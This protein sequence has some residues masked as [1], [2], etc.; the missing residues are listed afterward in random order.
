MRRYLFIISMLF[1]FGLQVGKSQGALD[2]LLNVD[3]KQQPLEKALYLLIDKADA[4]LSFSNDIIPDKEITLKAYNQPLSNILDL[5]LRDTDIQYRVV[6]S[7][8]VLYSDQ[9]TTGQKVTISG[10]V[11]DAYSGEALIGVSIYDTYS[12]KGTTT[13]EYGFYSLTLP[14]DEVAIKYSYVGYVLQPYRANLESNTQVDITL[15]P[16]TTHLAMVTIASDSLWSN[17]P[18]G[19]SVHTFDEEALWNLPGFGGEKD[20][21]RAIHLLPGIQT[22]TDGIGGFSVRGGNPDENLILIDDVPVYYFTHGAGLYSIV[23]SDAINKAT[24][25]KNDFPARYNGRLSSILDIRTKEGNKKEFNA[26]AGINLLGVKGYL[27]G[28][29]IPNRSSFFLSARK[30]L[31]NWY[32][33]PITREEKER[34]GEIGQTTYDFYDLNLK[35]NH[36]L[37]NKNHLFLSVYRGNDQF[38]DEGHLH[39]SYYYDNIGGQADYSYSNG[40]NWKNTTTSLRWNSVVSDQMFANLTLIYSRL[41]VDN[42][43]LEIDSSL[44]WISDQVASSKELNISRF[45][46]GIEDI[47]AKLDFD[48]MPSPQHYVRFGFNYTRHFF[49]PGAL[50]FSVRTDYNADLSGFDT[51]NFNNDRA[52]TNEYGAYIENN[53]MINDQLSLDAGLAHVNWE[54][55]DKIYRSWQPRLS[56]YWQ[57]DPVLGVK[58]SYSRMEQFI[59]RLSRSSLGLP[60]DL[61]VP[62][63]VE[64]APKTA[65]VFSLEFDYVRNQTRFSFGGFYKKFDGL[66]EY[67]EGANFLNN[68][69]DNITS[70]Q[71]DSYGLE[72]LLE[73]NMPTTN[74]WLA[75][76]LSY[77][78]RQFENINFGRTY[79][80][81]L[82]RRHSVNLNARHQFNK[83][84]GASLSWVYTTGFAFNIP[85]EEYIVVVP[86]GDNDPGTTSGVPGLDFGAKNELRMPAYHRLDVNLNALFETGPVQHAISIGAYNLYNRKNPLYYRLKR[87]YNIENNSIQKNSRYVQAWLMPLVPHLDYTLKF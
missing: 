45:E 16:A 78:N 59:H 84:L 8:I 12:G 58:A 69:E 7:Q 26:S 21:I 79:P 72:I 39:K 75:Y 30:S 35:V 61:W 71:G 23:N 17:E 48:F 11:E 5:M 2:K 22:G 1:F 50:S 47:G 14:A 66:I 49:R 42:H 43:L 27:E 62:S 68:W 40:L 24:L 10:F 18:K 41:E 44:S 74:F 51:Q 70:G 46:S 53:F 3:I 32:L 31:V 52:S 54:F 34:N 9:A 36:K 57:I 67:S 73:H 81:R 29:I 56:M 19:T 83:W 65:D 60:S 85:Q 38:S 20:I 82:D 64:V 63:T 33:S 87:E 77:A 86:D 6:G 55:Q 15:Q 80:Y 13:N 25:Y 76:T 4:H 28:P 37:S